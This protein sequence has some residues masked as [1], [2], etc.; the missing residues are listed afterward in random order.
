MT[1]TA[2]TLPGLRTDL[3]TRAAY[4]SDASIYRRMPVGILEP[5]DA[6]EVRRAVLWAVEQNLPVI[7]RGGG[8]SVAG[9]SIAV[10]VVRER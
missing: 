3:T 1:A 5:R 10:R 2:S 4:T 6:G 9:N 7:S 8:T